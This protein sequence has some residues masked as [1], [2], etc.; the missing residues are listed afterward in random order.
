VK[1]FYQKYVDVT[2]QRAA[3]C[4]VLQKQKRNYGCSKEAVTEQAMDVEQVATSGRN[5]EDDDDEM[6]YVRGASPIMRNGYSSP[7][8]GYRDEP[9]AYMESGELV[10][11]LLC[12]L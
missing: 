2:I 10:S 11:A 3:L 12:L 9:F 7:T 6:L 5:E 4:V 1:L 8:H